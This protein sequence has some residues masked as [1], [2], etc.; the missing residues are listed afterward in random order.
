MAGRSA[1]PYHLTLFG[2]EDSETVAQRNARLDYE[3]AT[4][5]I[6]RH[7]R[8]DVRFQ[9]CF[10]CLVLRVAIRSA[11]AHEAHGAHQTHQ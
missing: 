8:H 3:F 6:A 2:W 1:T 7:S 10:S 11:L 4:L 5:V 9:S